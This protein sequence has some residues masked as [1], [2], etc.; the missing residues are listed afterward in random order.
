VPSKNQVTVHPQTGKKECIF[1]DLAAVYPTPEEQGTEL[2]FEEIMAA[3]RGW[4]DRSWDEETVDENLVPD[5]VEPLREIE[6]ISRG[7][8]EKLVIHNDNLFFDENGVAQEQP[9]EPRMNKKK[10]LMEI[11]ETQIS[12]WNMV[13]AKSITGT[14]RDANK[15]NSQSKAR[16]T[17]RTKAPQ[18]EP[19][20]TY[21]DYAHQG[22]Y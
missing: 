3:N 22:R 10:R 8:P 17:V 5:A 18:E 16:L 21:N 2:S 15:S 4:L 12:K 14:S 7:A 20:R 1:V 11:N 6:E 9:K 19:V 13:L